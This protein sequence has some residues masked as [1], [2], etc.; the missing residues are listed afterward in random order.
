MAPQQMHARR[1]QAADGRGDGRAVER[2]WEV[3]GA[4]GRGGCS[5]CE[6]LC[7]RRAQGW[8]R[9]A[10]HH[11]AC[12]LGGTCKAYP[13]PRHSEH[14]AQQHTRSTS[15][16]ARVHARPSL[17]RKRP[18]SPQAHAGQQVEAALPGGAAGAAGCRAGGGGGGGGGG[19]CAAPAGPAHAPNKPCL[20]P[21]FHTPVSA[22]P[23]PYASSDQ[24]PPVRVPNTVFPRYSRAASIRRR[25]LA[26]REAC[27]AGEGGLA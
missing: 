12:R 14:H 1:R 5:A 8:R 26:W 24:H 25:S 19:R 23:R 10:A 18:A 20:L 2:C 6:A 17:G 27:T 13:G 7:S 11:C 15:L 21:P 9:W 22:G 3:E 4:R 16:Q